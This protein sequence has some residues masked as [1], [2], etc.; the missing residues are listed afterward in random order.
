MSYSST[1]EEFIFE[2]VSILNDVT[3]LS[4]SKE[5]TTWFNLKKWDKK[6]IEDLGGLD[7]PH[8]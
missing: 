7:T 5:G 2:F 8:A 3:I 6:V 1:T 4:D